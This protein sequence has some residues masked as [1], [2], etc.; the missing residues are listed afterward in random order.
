MKVDPR[1]LLCLAFGSAIL[2]SVPVS[3]QAA[4][5]VADFAGGTWPVQG[6]GVSSLSTSTDPAPGSGPWGSVTVGQYWGQMTI[7]SWATGNTSVAN[8]NGNSK[9]E[10]DL[11]LPSSGW[12]SG[13]VTIDL[14][15]YIDSTNDSTNNGVEYGPAAA[16]YDISGMKDQ[17]IHFATDYSAAGILPDA[18]GGGPD[19]TL[20]IYPNYNWMWDGGNSQSISYTPQQFYIDNI[21]L[22]SVPEPSAAA[23]LGAMG[24]LGLLRR[25]RF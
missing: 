24:V 4:V 9:V 1:S 8:L 7:P 10:F 5:M 12:L 6:W 21:A 22:T 17:I 19:L 13:N 2:C 25:R 3:S 20:N 15:L 18:A 23:A 11:I 16:S 14:G